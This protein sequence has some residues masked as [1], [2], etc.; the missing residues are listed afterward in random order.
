M[1]IISRGY[2]LLTC[3]IAVSD[4][5]SIWLSRHFDKFNNVRF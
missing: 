5:V 1:S 3:H 4:D 2:D